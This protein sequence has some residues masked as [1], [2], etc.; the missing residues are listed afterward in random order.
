MEQSVRPTQ[1]I[2]H[3]GHL[4][5]L[6][7]SG[8]IWARNMRKD[9]KWIQ[10]VLPLVQVRPTPEPTRGTQTYRS[11]DPAGDFGD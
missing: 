3:D 1:I 5:M 2:S 10:L 8:R 11:A 7:D 6:D 9:E 4:V